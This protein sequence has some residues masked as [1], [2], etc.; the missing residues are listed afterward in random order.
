MKKRILVIE[1]DTS[2]SEM[3]QS[4]L[5]QEGY[6]IVCAFDGEEALKKFK[7]TP[8]DLIILDI[9]LPRLDGMEF[10]KKA[11]EQSTL[12]VLIVSA[13]DTDVDKV[14][15][16]GFGADDYLAKPFSMIELGARVKAAIRR[17]HDYTQQPESNSSIVRGDLEL[18]MR[19]FS[20]RKQGVPIKLTAKEFEIIKLF[21]ENP[22]RVFTKE[23]I[24][25][26]IWNEDY[27]GEE[28]VINV[29]IRRLREKIED[30]P[31]DPKILVTVWGIGYKLG[32]Q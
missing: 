22:D 6:H 17:S 12:P 8:V 26:F 14:L 24:Y 11:R 7:E 16:L 27:Y 1:D 30:D 21:F 15:G 29:H 31:S 3:I 32:E 2:I 4:Y 9:M 28:N 13:K 18:D 25:T 23:Q 20:I 19:I 5:T 10:L